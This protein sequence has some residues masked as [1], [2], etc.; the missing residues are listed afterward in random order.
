MEFTLGLVCLGCCVFKL[1]KKWPPLNFISQI[2]PHFF[3]IYKRSLTITCKTSRRERKLNAFGESKWK[4][5]AGKNTITNSYLFKMRF[6]VCLFVEKLSRFIIFLLLIDCWINWGVDWNGGGVKLLEFL[7]EILLGKWI[8]LKIILKL[9]NVGFCYDDIQFC[10]R[11]LYKF[12][13]D[14]YSLIK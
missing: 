1:T 2:T 13:H 4:T 14:Y 11:K 3:Q 7:F 8:Y 12:R 10:F 9:W 6:F 5:M